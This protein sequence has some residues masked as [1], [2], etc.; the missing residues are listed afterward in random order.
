MRGNLKSDGPAL[1]FLK[2]RFELFHL[3][4]D[5]ITAGPIVPS[6]GR[7]NYFQAR[8]RTLNNVDFWVD[9]FEGSNLRRHLETREEKDCFAVTES[10][11]GTAFSMFLQP[12]PHF[13]Q[14]T[15]FAGHSQVINN[16]HTLGTR[17]CRNRILK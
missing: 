13:V 6:D 10:Y 12:E 14:N 7:S 8:I 17:H 3:V 5:K 16:G 11:A 2:Q 15:W 1:Q 9:L 4:F